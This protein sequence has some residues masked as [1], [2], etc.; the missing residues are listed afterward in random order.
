MAAVVVAIPRQRKAPGRR[1]CVE[2]EIDCYDPATNYTTEF[3]GYCGETWRTALRFEEH[4]ETQP[5][6]DTIIRMRVVAKHRTKTDAQRGEAARI[7]GLVT[8]IR[9]AYNVEENLD[10][11]NRIPPWTALGQRWMRDDANRRPRWVPPK[12]RAS[13]SVVAIPVPVRRVGIS[14]WLI[15]AGAL[16][17][18]LMFAGC[19]AALSGPWV[20]AWALLGLWPTAGQW[21]WVPAMASASALLRFGLWLP[22]RRKRRRR[23]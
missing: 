22:Y 21:A 1:S 3:L 19:W 9:P 11:L 7:R 23:R 15:P 10:N 14:W 2:Y 20:A 16:T 13:T 6:G 8:G 17:W 12:E 18:L 4:C 5:W